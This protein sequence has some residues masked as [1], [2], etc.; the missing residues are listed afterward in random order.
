MLVYLDIQYVGSSSI[1]LEGVYSACIPVGKGQPHIF[2]VKLDQGGPATPLLARD[3]KTE[4]GGFTYVN[5]VVKISPK[6]VWDC[7]SLGNDSDF[8]TTT[9][10]HDT[11]SSGPLAFVMKMCQPALVVPSRS[12]ITRDCYQ[13]HRGND[14]GRAIKSCLL[15]WA[16]PNILTIIVENASSNDTSVDY[17]KT[18]LVKWNDHCILQGKWTHVRCMAHIMNLVVQD[19]LKDVGISVNRVRVVVRW[20]KQSLA[21]LKRF[22]E[23]AIMDNIVCQ[24]SLCLDVPTRWNYTYLML[25]VAIEYEKV[26][27]M[28][29]EEDYVF[30]RDLGEGPGVPTSNDLANVRRLVGFLQHFYLLTLKGTKYITSNTYL[31]AISCIDSVLKECLASEDNDLKKMAMKMKLK[32]DKY[33]GD[34]KKFNLLVFIASVFYRKTKMEYLQVTLNE[35][36]VAKDSK[37]ELDRYLTEEIEGDEAYFKSGDFTVLGWWKRRSPAFPVLSLVA[38]DILAIPISTVASESTFSTGGR[39]LDSFRSSLSPE[40]VQALIC[41]Q[42]WVRSGDVAVNLEENIDDLEKF[43]DVGQIPVTIKAIGVDMDKI[44]KETHGYVGA[45]LADLAALCTEAIQHGGYGYDVPTG[46]IN[47]V[48]SLTGET[49]RLPP[50]TFNINHLTQMFESTGLTQDSHTQNT[51]SLS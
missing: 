24:K 29:S 2:H 31:D 14:I 41:C 13:L 35:S 34:I 8:T 19:G 28:F 33:W 36:G 25:S 9:L 1:E 3:T 22:K 15:E 27:D 4:L 30:M 45:H 44:S 6:G 38:R 23:F 26:F 5:E 10:L 21:R 47:S 12:T 49:T 16:L 32:F 11:G 48:V 43:E 7:I 20:V 42:D 18:K 40:T 39:V 17:L 37:S 50:S 46:I 51:I